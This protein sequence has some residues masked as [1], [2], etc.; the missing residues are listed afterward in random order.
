MGPFRQE[1][2]SLD[3]ILWTVIFIGM[4][5]SALGGPFSLGSF[6]LMPTPLIILN[7]L[8]S[9]LSA[10]VILIGASV[11]FAAE[12]GFSAGMAF[13][14]LIGLLSQIQGLMIRRVSRVSRVLFWSLI[15]TF[16]A[17]LTLLAA[18]TV[19]GS[20]IGAGFLA[21]VGDNLRAAVRSSAYG[22]AFSASDVAGFFPAF[23]LYLVFIFTASNFFLA[24]WVLRFKGIPVI[25][26]DT[27]S[28]FQLPPR[29]MAGTLSLIVLGYGLQITGWPGGPV[30]VDTLIYLTVFVF[31]FEGLAIC[32]YFMKR[33][34]IPSIWHY[35]I[36][37]ALLLLAG[38]IGLALAGFSDVLLDLRKQRRAGGNQ[39]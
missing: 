35:V 6:F 21:G 4:V 5:V 25:P 22:D 34:G 30:L 13:F 3:R 38:P 7:V 29:I 9:P 19:L 16:G 1:K 31:M 15:F 14:L 18:E 2:S 11:L 32:S 26:L 33:Q 23:V 20:A 12:Q 36:L 39:G 17:G 10:G 28:E 8:V 24:R 27:L 37:T